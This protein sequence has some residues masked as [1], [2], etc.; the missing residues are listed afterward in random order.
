MASGEAVIVVFVIL[1]AIISF[2][3]SDTFNK[4]IENTRES[5]DIVNNELAA[6]RY[7]ENKETGQIEIVQEPTNI[8]MQ[9][10]QKTKIMD[11]LLNKVISIK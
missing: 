9:T 3:S 8:L 7:I 11:A 4:T 1:V 6:Q 10:P 2:F 5:T